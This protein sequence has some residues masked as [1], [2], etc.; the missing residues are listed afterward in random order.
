MSWILQKAAHIKTHRRLYG[1]MAGYI[2]VILAGS[3]STE[4]KDVE[5]GLR[6]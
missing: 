6:L 2:V 3:A 5:S 4:I 1:P